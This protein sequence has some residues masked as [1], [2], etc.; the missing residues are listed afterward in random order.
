MERII[1]AAP[2]K[3]MKG[4][5]IMPT[6]KP[7]DK[8]CVFCAESVKKKADVC[9]KCGNPYGPQK[10]NGI[11]SFGAG[12]TGWSPYAEDPCFRKNRNK[13]T[14]ATLVFLIIVSLIIFIF[15]LF[16]GDASFKSGGMTAFACA[17][18]V[19]WI[20]WIVWYIIKSR[21]GKVWEGT[22]DQKEK[23]SREYSKKNA[24][25]T[26]YKETINIYT[27]YF[28][29]NEGKKKKDSRQEDSRWYD[30]LQEGDRVKYHGNLL[31]Y[32]EKYD[33][34][35]DNV[36]PCASC[37]SLR[38]IREDYCGR[39]GAI[40]LKSGKGHTDAT[41]ST[42]TTPQYV[43]P[44]TSDGPTPHVQA[45]PVNDNT[46]TVSPASAPADAVGGIICPVCG[47]VSSGGAFCEECGTKL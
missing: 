17:M 44:A 16:S 18:G 40:M 6:A 42:G 43:P 31:N 39:C 30:Y 13:T 9:P 1:F 32:Y 37:G 35:S 26:R 3:Q 10:F 22:V 4:L 46:E 20:F 36:L 11:T 33:K 2:R 29:T 38:D 27:V 25:G 14:V 7:D 24:D 19:L 45:V 8:Y 5:L 41:F 15:M 12:G 34:S 47:T 21:P 23:L 28:R